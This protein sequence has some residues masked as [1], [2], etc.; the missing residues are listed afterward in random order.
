MGENIDKNSKKKGL[1]LCGSAAEYLTFMASTGGGDE[2]FE[3][4]Y[5]DKNIWLT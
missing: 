4:R 2:S 1:A 5:E 3:M